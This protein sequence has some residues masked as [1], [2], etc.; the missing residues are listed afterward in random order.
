MDST[1]KANKRLRLLISSNA[2]WSTTGYGQQMAELAPL[3]RDAGYPVAVSCFY[4]LQGGIVGIDGILCYPGLGDPYG[5]DAILHHSRDF[6]A[7]VV[8]TMQDIWT[9]N[10]QFLTQVPRYIPIVFVDHDPIQEVTLEK[11]RIAYRLI[12]CSKFGQKQLLNNNLHS[13]YIPMMVNTEIFQKRDRSFRKHI[14]VPDDVFLFGMVGANKDNPP[15]KSFQEVLDA[16]ALFHKNH[17][18]SMLY[19]HAQPQQAGGFPIDTYAQY[20]GLQDAVRF[21]P[22]MYQMMFRTDKNMMS[23]VY[24]AMDTLVAPSF[25]E[26]FCVPLIEAQACEVPV[27]ANSFTAQSELVPE[28]VGKLTGVA[29]KRYSGLGSYI[30]IPD[31]G[32]I[33]SQMEAIYKADRE[34]MGKAAR[35]YVSQYDSQKVFNE[36][37]LPF[38]SMLEREVYGENTAGA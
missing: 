8:I 29:Y 16:F 33:H 21:H 6:Q 26:G 38:L 19:F 4:G 32:S 25:S 2:P 37:W 5:A 13:R 15:R 36:L 10:P 17:P 9:L 11:C 27:I 24:S 18:K 22:D 20:I 1:T 23:Y 34:K 12:A 7:D 30:G 31:V 3:I 28:K 14:K 35:E